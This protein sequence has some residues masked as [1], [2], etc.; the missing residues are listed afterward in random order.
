MA[1]HSK[2]FLSCPTYACLENTESLRNEGV[3]I[4]YKATLTS[5]LRGHNALSFLAVPKLDLK[6]T[7]LLIR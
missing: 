1:R 2:A 7:K 4:N 5:R 6:K 3:L